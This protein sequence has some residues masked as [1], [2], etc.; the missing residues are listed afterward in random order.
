MSLSSLPPPVT[1]AVTANTTESRRNSGTNNN[2]SINSTSIANNNMANNNNFNPIEMMQMI[3]GLLKTEMNAFRSEFNIQKNSSTSISSTANSNNTDDGIVTFNTNNDTPAP[4]RSRPERVSI[5]AATANKSVLGRSPSELRQLNQFL[6][7]APNNNKRS[8][9]AT[10]SNINNNNSNN[11]DDSDSENP[12]DYTSLNST[13]TNNSNTGNYKVS[14]NTE[15][16]SSNSILLPELFQVSFE[17]NLRD[18]NKPRQFKDLSQMQ[19]MFR[20]QLFRCIQQDIDSDDSSLGLTSAW[21]RYEQFIMKL[22][23]EK[24]FHASQEYHWLS[25]IHI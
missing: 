20:H 3:K 15:L 12:T 22:S 24:G 19:D 21:I 4:I 8:N 2:T 23:I 1:A 14:T 18:S 25:L 16:S 6:T 10:A 11:N 17:T 9:T 7:A 5:A 13:V